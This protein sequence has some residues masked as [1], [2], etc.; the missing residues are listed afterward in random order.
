MQLAKPSL[1]RSLNCKRE[2]LESLHPECCEACCSL[3]DTRAL[4]WNHGKPFKASKQQFNYEGLLHDRT[5]Q[6]STRV[7][8]RTFE[9][10]ARLANLEID[11][12]FSGN[13]CH[14]WLQ[15]LVST[16]RGS[17]FKQCD[18]PCCASIVMLLTW[19]SPLRTWGVVEKIV[20]LCV[21][22]GPHA[23]KSGIRFG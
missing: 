2:E 9:W 11:T 1:E 20:W 7:L 5:V 21:V 19:F 10:F 22:C 15:N 18:Q 3:I 14:Q 6:Y 12:F 16:L 8:T 4:R 17:A 13:I 23:L